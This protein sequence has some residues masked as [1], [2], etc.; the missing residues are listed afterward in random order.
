MLEFRLQFRHPPFLR[1]PIRWFILLQKWH[2]CVKTCVFLKQ[3]SI[4]F[5]L[6]LR[7]P[8]SLRRSIR[9][10]I[11]PLLKASFRL[12]QSSTVW[13]G[14]QTGG[15][16]ERENCKRNSIFVLNFESMF[17]KENGVF[18]CVSTFFAILGQ[19]FFEIF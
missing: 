13:N 9:W 6:Q 10:F 5:R 18:K 17:S 1:S 3:I 2:I 16:L 8:Q 11:L 7:H 19:D 14:A 15:Q 12:N 4:E